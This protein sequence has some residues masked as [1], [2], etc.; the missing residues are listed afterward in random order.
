MLSFED[1]KFPEDET[2][3]R[4]LKSYTNVT[5]KELALFVDIFMRHYKNYYFSEED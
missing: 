2:V 4:T 5:V 1:L 3:M